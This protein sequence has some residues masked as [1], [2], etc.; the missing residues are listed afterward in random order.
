[1]TDLSVGAMRAEMTLGLLPSRRVMHL[2]AAGTQEA[3]I[4]ILKHRL[5]NQEFRVLRIAD[6]IQ[7]G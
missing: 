4:V 3:D 7:N 5:Q 2:T 6:A 1:M